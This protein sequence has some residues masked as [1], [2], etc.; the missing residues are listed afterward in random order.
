MKQPLRILHLYPRELGINGD[1][2]NVT[3]LVARAQW[4]G[5]SAEV[6]GHSVGDS[7]P[8]D[9]DLIHIGSG[10][11][12]A[13]RAVHNDVQRISAELR[14]RAAEGV[15]VVA[16]AGGWQL[17]GLELETV[18]GEVL[19]GAGVFPSRARIERARRVGE[20]VVDTAE[21]RIAGFENHSTSTVLQS[22]ARAFGTVVASGSAAAK[23]P[24]EQRTEGIRMGASIATNLHGPLL[25][26]NP[27]LADE[28]L[29][30]MLKRRGGA[31][32]LEAVPKTVQADDFARRS[33]EAIYSRLSLR[34]R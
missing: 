2:G 26:M 29:A 32:T 11:L 33:R 28:L 19:A 23:I 6:V 5:I 34:S 18:D 21:G 24:G 30:V 9:V 14:S 27:E 10:P 15:P 31:A 13:Q 7:F 3:T 20:I 4:R 17:L 22:G 8:A 12:S 1:V 16:V 25:P